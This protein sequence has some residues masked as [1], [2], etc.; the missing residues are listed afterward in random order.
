ME[1]ML[2]GQW[3]DIEEPTFGPLKRIL[4]A[5]NRMVAPDTPDAAKIECINAILAAL[6]GGQLALRHLREG[7]LM[8]LLEALPDVCGLERLRT[9]ASS[10]PVDWDSIYIHIAVSLGW[11]WHAIDVG[12]SMSRLRALRD[13][14]AKHPPTHLLAAAYLGYKPPVESTASFLKALSARARLGKAKA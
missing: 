10:S 8:G 2:G 6:T 9:G 14:Q 3:R 5:Y 7:E 4:A 1:L 11:D 13:Y 12:M